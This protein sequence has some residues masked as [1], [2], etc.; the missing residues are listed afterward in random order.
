LEVKTQTF[1]WWLLLAACCGLS[2]RGQDDGPDTQLYDT[3][4]P[5]TVPLTR[6]IMTRRNGWR[7]IPEETLPQRFTGAAVM[8]NDKL[9]VVFQKPGGGPEVYSKLTGQRLADVAFLAGGAS[10][11]EELTD[12]RITE[13]T[14][15]AI[16]VEA[17]FGKGAVLRFRLTVGEGSLEIQSPQGT[18]AVAVQSDTRYVVVP[19]Y[20][21]DDMVYGRQR[22]KGLIP[23]ENFCLG[24]LGSGDAILMTVWQ[25]NQQDVTL[26]P[27][28]QGPRSGGCVTRIQCLKNK[29]IWL[30]F[31]ENRGI[32]H[33]RSDRQAEDWKPPFPAKWRSSWRRA[34]DSAD[35]WDLETGPSPEQQAGTHEGPLLTY[36]IDRTPA[37]PLTVS[38]PTDVMRNTLGV[39]PCQYILACEGLGAQGDPTPNS[40]MGWVEKQFLQRKQRKAA[41]DIKDRLAHMTQHVRE[42]HSRIGRYAELSLR[43]GAALAPPTAPESLRWLGQELGRCAAAGMVPE[44]APEHAQELAGDVQALLNRENAEGACLRLGEQLRAIGAI[45]D[46]SLARCRMTVRRLRQEARMLA[47]E[48]GAS[49]AVTEVQRLADQALQGN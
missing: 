6:E 35:S 17:G 12:Y 42:A 4:A 45:Q 16:R 38:C 37:T 9:L 41:D 30:A 7:L 44:A 47:A 49:G 27:A 11:A 34:N 40:V 39:G 2:A 13:N 1:G 48:G 26:A 5:L 36:L 25:S 8:L 3:G 46:R 24:L 32:W 10:A 33:V 28:G 18:G 23:A 22:F 29:N 15:G 21:G 14:A 20:F 19:D 31:L 43:V